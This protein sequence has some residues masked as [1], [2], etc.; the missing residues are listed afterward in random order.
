MANPY[1]ILI[2]PTAHRQIQ[3]LVP[4]TRKNVIKLLDSLAINPRPPVSRKIDG[5]TGLHCE[6]INNLRI[7]YKV[8]DQE[9]LVL[10][11][12]PV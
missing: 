2:A 5:M 11:V 4:K 1:H 10:L 12:K 6:D 7:I 3:E 9:V 8:D